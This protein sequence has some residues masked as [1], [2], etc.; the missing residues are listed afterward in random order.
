MGFQVFI[1]SGWAANI[2]GRVQ[3]MRTQALIQPY[4]ALQCGYFS[5][6]GSHFSA[7]Q[8]FKVL[9]LQGFGLLLVYR[10]FSYV[11][12]FYKKCTYRRFT[13]GSRK[14]HFVEGS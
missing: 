7:F 10:R 9:G 13:E 11:W 2:P 5:K 12:R 8:A 1:R 6:K 4:N 14:L 3:P